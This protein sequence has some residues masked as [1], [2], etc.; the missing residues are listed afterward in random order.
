[1]S[2]KGAET[3][4]FQRKKIFLSITLL[5]LRERKIKTRGLYQ[6]SILKKKASVSEDV[7]NRSRFTC[8]NTSV[9]TSFSRRQL[10]NMFTWALGNAHTF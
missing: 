6:I 4:I 8:Q 2:E 10:G 5:I 9:P 1:M 7:G 3:N